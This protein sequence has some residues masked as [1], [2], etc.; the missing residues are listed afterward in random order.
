MHNMFDGDLRLMKWV[1]AL[2]AHDVTVV[3]IL[4]LGEQQ[5]EEFTKDVFDAVCRIKMKF[6]KAIERTTAQPLLFGPNSAMD[7]TCFLPM[8]ITV[9]LT[10]LP[11]FMASAELVMTNISTDQAALLVLKSHITNINEPDNILAT[12]WSTSSS[13]CYWIGVTCDAHHHRVTA[14][15]LSYKHL[16]GIIP[17]HLGNLSFLT[18]LRFRNNSFQGSLPRELAQLHR[19]KWISFAGNNLSGDIPSWFG[20]F[21]KLQGL[22][23]DRNQFSGSIPTSLFNS[24]S[25]QIIDLSDNQLSGSIPRE[26]GNLTMLKKLR[27]DQNKFIEAPEEIGNI[28]LEVLQIQYNALTGPIPLFTFNISSLKVL[29]Y[30]NNDLSG[31]IPDNIC[32]NLPALKGLFLSHNQLAGNLPSQWSQCEELLELSL[33]FN[34]FTG[35]IPRNVGNLTNLQML[36]FSFNNLTGTIPQEI[37]NLQSLVELGIQTNHMNGPI[38]FEMFNI[39]TIEAIRVI[40]NQLSGNFPSTTAF[41]LPNLKELLI[42]VNEFSGDI[43]N[44]IS[45]ASQLIQLDA[46]YNSFSGL[47]TN[48]LGASTTLRIPKDIGNLIGL[49]MLRLNNNELTGLIPKSIGRLHKLQGLY[50]N[51]NK[52]EGFILSEICQLM[53]LGDLYLANNKLFG[54]IPTCLGNLISL[55]RLFLNSNELSSTIPTTFWGLKDILKLNLSSNSLTGSLHSDM[56]SL[57]VVITIDLSNNHLSGNIPSTIE[58]VIPKSMETISSLKYF[59]VSFNELQGG[60]PT[61]GPF[62]YLSGQSFMGND[63]LCGESRLAVPPCKTLEPQISRRKAIHILKYVL[64]AI[65]SATLVL[66]LGIF[67]LKKYRK[68]NVK[69]ASKMD[70]MVQTRTLG[71]IGYMAPDLSLRKW[72]KESLSHEGFDVM[73]ASLLMGENAN[74]SAIKDCLS[75]VM[76]LALSCSAELPQERKSMNVM[77]ASLLMGEN[78]NLSAIKDC[79]SS[80]MILALSCSAELPQERKSMKDV[81]VALHKIKMKLLKEVQ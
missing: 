32:K 2:I 79:L 48:P 80:V 31:S 26:I 18:E 62:A 42:G 47:L 61:E 70:T 21:P 12:N 13:F 29:A 71:T 7:Y 8:I 40:E 44:F 78:A 10:M 67:L 20:W 46:P 17:P 74:L 1:K 4:N 39:S 38:P 11:P 36:Y 55:R 5:V 22:N 19:L 30:T 45:N 57:K 63:A 81:S 56:G 35:S 3:V 6:F 25:L 69:T 41:L 15:D 53:S 65:T 76:I 60:I 9:L 77:G 64:P 34:H 14:L 68:H 75:S 49:T 59:N 27:L 24:S 51:D 52:L 72:V 23:L 16:A 73:G 43:L 50:L 58:G 54:P 37:G 66:V 28:K 33:S